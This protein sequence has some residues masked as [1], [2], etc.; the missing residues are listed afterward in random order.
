MIESSA[1]PGKQL[2]DLQLFG[3]VENSVLPHLANERKRIL[4]NKGNPQTVAQIAL[5]AAFYQQGIY[6]HL[7]PLVLALIG[8]KNITMLGVEHVERIFDFPK[9]EEDRNRAV[10]VIRETLV[11]LEKQTLSLQMAAMESLR[12]P[13]TK[14][15]LPHISDRTTYNIGNQNDVRKL[16]GRFLEVYDASLNVVRSPARMPTNVSWPIDVIPRHRNQLLAIGAAFYVP[17]QFF[18]RDK[19]TFAAAVRPGGEKGFVSNHFQGFTLLYHDSK[20]LKEDVQE[21]EAAP[22]RGFIGTLF[23]PSFSLKDLG[24]RDIALKPRLEVDMARHRMKIVI[25]SSFILDIS[26]PRWLNTLPHINFMVAVFVF[27]RITM[28][29]GKDEYLSLPLDVGIKDVMSKGVVPR[30][31][32]SGGISIWLTASEAKTTVHD[33]TFRHTSSDSSL[34]DWIMTEEATQRIFGVGTAKKSLKA[35][36]EVKA[37][38]TRIYLSTTTSGDPEIIPVK[39]DVPREYEITIEGTLKSS[40]AL[41]APPLTVGWAALQKARKLTELAFH[42][43][44]GI[45]YRRV[46]VVKDSNVEVVQRRVEL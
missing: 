9:T 36:K 32:P 42:P 29:D 16:V 30:F 10:G 33:R 6:Q 8:D 43:R 46:R 37:N 27:L 1:V 2:I 23:G 22:K 24:R 18:N 26:E 20:P 5:R 34:T 31:L 28:S 17:P 41:G 4:E 12:G 21:L 25:P 35:W 11:R 13:P 44:S 38:V 14:I 39:L 19:P 40:Y 7:T 15:L 45:K 3:V